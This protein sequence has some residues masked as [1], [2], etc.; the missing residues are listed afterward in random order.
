MTL[1]DLI[2]A[3]EAPEAEVDPDVLMAYLAAR[4]RS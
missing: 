1:G 4:G 2:S 3:P